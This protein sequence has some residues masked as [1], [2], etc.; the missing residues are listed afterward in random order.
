MELFPV[1]MHIPSADGG[2]VSELSVM[3]FA[4]TSIGI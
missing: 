3:E 4:D 2:S 1:A